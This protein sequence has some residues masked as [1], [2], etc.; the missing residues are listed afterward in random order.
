M[1]R[2]ISI[3]Q[4][5]LLFSGCFN[6]SFTGGGLPGINSISI[7]MADD[8]TNEFQ[9]RENVTNALIDKFM[10]DGNLKLENINNSD[11]ILRCSI[12]SISD[13]SASINRD[14]LASQFELNI[15]VSII[16]EERSTGQELIKTTIT[17]RSTYSDLS[18]RSSAIE[19]AIDKLTSDILEEIIS[20]W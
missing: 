6:Y 2:I 16:L 15:R 12:Q 8:K 20:A 19:E 11:S 5:L 10:R 14:E 9:L 17:G 13:R 1:K 3:F 18:E 4:I 7:P